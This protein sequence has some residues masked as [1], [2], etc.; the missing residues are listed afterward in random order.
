[1]ITN[2]ENNTLPENEVK[3]LQEL[4][5]RA[6]IEEAKLKQFQG[7]Q[8]I[9]NG[10][11]QDAIA[12]K[13]VVMEALAK[14]EEKLKEVQG[15]VD[16]KLL[17]LSEYSSSIEEIKKQISEMTIELN[18]KISNFD[19]KV[20]A[21]EESVKSFNL[22]VEVHKNN[23]KAFEEEKALHKVKVDKLIEALK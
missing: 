16:K 8:R 11:I 18:C 19:S 14:V 21:H 3:A 2:P 9:I 10:E 1:M 22:E 20:S 15:L 7:A 6:I 4:Q 5:Q 12:Q 17:E 13:T 23:V